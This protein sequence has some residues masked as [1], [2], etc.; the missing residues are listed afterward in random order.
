MGYHE[1]FTGSV[2]FD[3]ETIGSPEAET[4]LDP[5]QAPANYKDE[6]KIAAYCAEKRVKQIADAG[7]EPDL[8]E[9]VAVGFYE[10]DLSLPVSVWTRA[11]CDEATLLRRAWTM[12]GS[13]LIVG[14][15]VLGFDLPVLI[16]RS[17]LLGVPVT[18]VNLDRY[19]TP[20]IDVLERL[21]FHGK[22]TYRSLKFYAK[23]FGIPITD[24][25]T[26]ADIGDLV[27]KQDWAAI[28]A[29]CASDVTATAQLAQRLGWLQDTPV[30][31]EV[32]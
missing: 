16:R 29:H 6:A 21:S 26:G 12:L 14:Y 20:H 31:A 27:A 9:V 11:D 25:T 19:R 8:C 23:R 3:L 2:V 5:V 30:L 18:A 1:E 15:N 24:Q 4:F 28:A 13:R 17:Q 22:L 32:V 7:L 10:P